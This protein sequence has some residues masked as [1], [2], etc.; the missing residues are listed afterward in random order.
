[1]RLP[2]NIIDILYT[3]NMAGYQAYVVGGCVRDFLLNRS[4]SDYDVCTNAL[5]Q[6]VLSLF[7]HA[8][9]TGIKHG[10]IT[11]LTP[12]PVEVTTFRSESSYTDHRHPDTVQFVSFYHGRSKTQGFYDQR[13]GISSC[14]RIDRPF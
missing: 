7:D 14:Y 3:L 4:C 13:N 2:Q 6:T 8:I 12:D 9:P 1:M 11:V 5:P 10:T